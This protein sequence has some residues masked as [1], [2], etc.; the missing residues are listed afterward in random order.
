[1]EAWLAGCEARRAGGG[2]VAVRG[3]AGERLT[4]PAPTMQAGERRHFFGLCPSCLAVGD[5]QV[6]GDQEKTEMTSFFQN[7]IPFKI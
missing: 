4:I 1:M 3:A 5:H 7:L 6:K 2:G